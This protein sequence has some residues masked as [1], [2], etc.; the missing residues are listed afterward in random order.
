MIQKHK[1]LGNRVRYKVVVIL[2]IRWFSYKRQPIQI[3]LEWLM[4]KVQIT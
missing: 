3:I 2:R 1:P 4:E